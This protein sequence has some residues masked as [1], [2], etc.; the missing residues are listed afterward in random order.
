MAMVT[1]GCGDDEMVCNGH[2]MLK[3]GSEMSASRPR[4]L[5]AGWQVGMWVWMWDLGIISAR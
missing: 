4:M 2:G 1:Y 3:G 5:L